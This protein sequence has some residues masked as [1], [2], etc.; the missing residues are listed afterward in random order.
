MC[1]TNLAECFGM[2][3]LILEIVAVHGIRQASLFQH[4]SSNAKHELKV[5]LHHL[6]LRAR[7]LHAQK[8]SGLEQNNV[9]N[10]GGEDSNDVLMK[11]YNHDG[12]SLSAT[13]V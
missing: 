4:I 13:S 3:G 12:K 1:L 11:Q 8:H 2:P 10:G 9:Q 7:L 6:S 5:Y